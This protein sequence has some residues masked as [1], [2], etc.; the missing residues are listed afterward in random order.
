VV[1][2]SG[3]RVSSFP[4]PTRPRLESKARPSRFPKIDYALLQSSSGA[5]KRSG[6]NATQIKY[7]A[8][9]LVALRLVQ[10]IT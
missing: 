6:C 5:R 9:R 3:L 10:V 8:M 1:A 2:L 4:T 7:I